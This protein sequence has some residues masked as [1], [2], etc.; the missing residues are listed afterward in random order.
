M[1]RR[2]RKNPTSSENLVVEIIEDCSH[3]DV[4]SQ[5]DLNFYN[6]IETNNSC[7]QNNGDGI[8]I[9]IINR[10]TPHRGNQTKKKRDILKRKDH[11][12]DTPD[13]VNSLESSEEI[14]EDAS[15]MVV[16]GEEYDVTDPSVE[17]VNLRQTFDGVAD[18]QA[19]A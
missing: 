17:A 15:A 5:A 13:T 10:F 11:L 6:S 19:V 7:D 12:P 14:S 2:R 1:L 18:S 16:V 4:E 8:E 3:D 9:E